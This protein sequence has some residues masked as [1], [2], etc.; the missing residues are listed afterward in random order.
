[1]IR[2]LP[3]SL[4]LTFQKSGGKNGARLDRRNTNSVGAHLGAGRGSRCRTDQPGTNRF[5]LR[6]RHSRRTREGG[7]DG[8]LT[9]LSL[10]RSGECQPGRIPALS[11]RADRSPY[12]RPLHTREGTVARGIAVTHSWKE[13]SCHRC[14]F[15]IPCTCG[16]RTGNFGSNRGGR[17]RTVSI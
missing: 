7:R 15:D 1:M 12:G 4:P 9:R 3:V 14:S 16:V 17:L 2:S 11:S 8:G 5:G 10:S 6:S 13:A